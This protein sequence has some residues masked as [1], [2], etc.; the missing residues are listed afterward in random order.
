[1]Q[2]TF[3]TAPKWRMLSLPGEL[4]NQHRGAVG[5]EQPVDVEIAERAVDGVALAAQRPDDADAHCER[6]EDRVNGACR[7]KAEHRVPPVGRKRG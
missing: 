2:I 6:R 3:V 4:I 7:G 1:M 5:S